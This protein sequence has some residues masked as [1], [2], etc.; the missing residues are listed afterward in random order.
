MTPTSVPMTNCRKGDGVVRV[1]NVTVTIQGVSDTLTIFEFN[2][3]EVDLRLVNVAFN[4]FLS[5]NPLSP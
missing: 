1:P 3:G 2:I 4:P 5:H